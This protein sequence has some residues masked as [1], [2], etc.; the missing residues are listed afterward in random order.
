MPFEPRIEFRFQF[1]ADLQIIRFG[2]DAVPDVFDEENS[3]GWAQLKRF[4]K[5]GFCRHG[6]YFIPRTMMNASKRITA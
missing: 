4:G 6:D 1:V 5:K 2:R 3:L